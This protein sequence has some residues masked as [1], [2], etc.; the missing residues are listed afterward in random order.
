M[1]TLIADLQGWRASSSDPFDICTTS[2]DIPVVLRTDPDMAVKVTPLP[3]SN[4][5]SNT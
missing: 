2:I 4:M 5:L 3:E 1:Y